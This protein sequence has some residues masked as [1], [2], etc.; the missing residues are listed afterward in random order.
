MTEIELSYLKTVE[1]ISLFNPYLV[2]LA[3]ADLSIVSEFLRH[4]FDAISHETRESITDDDYFPAVLIGT[5]PQGITA[6]GEITRNSPQLTK[7]MLVVD[8]AR[9]PG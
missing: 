6:L 5:G 8:D 1:Y 3:N 4:H 2:A 9:Y 7:N